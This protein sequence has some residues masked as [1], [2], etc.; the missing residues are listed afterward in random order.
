MAGCITEAFRRKNVHALMWRS[1]GKAG[2]LND[3]GEHLN[4]MRPT[5]LM[6]GLGH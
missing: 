6:L 3:C 5:D 1:R 2:F 4:Q